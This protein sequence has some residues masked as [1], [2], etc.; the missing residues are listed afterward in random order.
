MDVLR[1]NKKNKQKPKIRPSTQWLAQQN[2]QGSPANPMA[3]PTNIKNMSESPELTLA[4]EWVKTHCSF[5]IIMGK[6]T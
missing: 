4:S 3:I 2:S 5:G 6:E 1:K